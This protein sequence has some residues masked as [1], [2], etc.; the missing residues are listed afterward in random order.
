MNKTILKIA[1]ATI[2]LILASSYV[3][4]NSNAYAVWGHGISHG[5]SFGNIY[6]FQFHDG[7]TI[8]GKT[9]DISKF[10][11]VI[12]T[13]TFYV[14]VPS[15]ITLKIFHTD[16]AT[17]IKHV[18]IYFNQGT[19][20]SIISSSTWIEYNAKGGV[21]TH[22]PNNIFKNVTANVSIKGHYMYITLK[23]TPQS[24]LDES[25]IV[26][27]AWDYRNDSAKSTVVNALQIVKWQSSIT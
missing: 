23:I 2:F 9:F 13:Q 18:A 10:S 8:D 3:G 27:Q 22:D 1:S 17:S 20:P 24:S 25:N 6:G 5:P 16:G 26:L 11:Q 19:T 7:L 14:N 21:T 4:T 12:P 15:T